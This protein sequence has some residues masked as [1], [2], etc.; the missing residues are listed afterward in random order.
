MPFASPY[1][2]GLWMS[3]SSCVTCSMV[4]CY[5][6]LPSQ[7]PSQPI[8]LPLHLLS[9]DA[10][11]TLLLQPPA[12]L[13]TSRSVKH[14]VLLLFCNVR[15]CQSSV[16][17]V[18]PQPASAAGCCRMMVLVGLGYMFPKSVPK[19]YFRHLEGNKFKWTAWGPQYVNKIMALNSRGWFF[20]W[21]AVR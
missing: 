5:A 21:P 11:W 10:R 6:C 15:C 12:L 2:F 7:T 19:F 4:V 1:L 17:A 9:H 20:C 18:L 3:C 8:S 13:P 14:T 16:D